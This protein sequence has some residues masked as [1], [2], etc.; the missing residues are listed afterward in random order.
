MAL[1]NE[2]LHISSSF[3][4]HTERSKLNFTKKEKGNA[5]KVKENSGCGKTTALV[6]T[7]IQFSFWLLKWNFQSVD[8]I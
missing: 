3:A 6:C 4:I 8:K 2:K 5:I 1:Q 7:K